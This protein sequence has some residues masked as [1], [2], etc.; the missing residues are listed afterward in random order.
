MHFVSPKVGSAVRCW[1]NTKTLY[2]SALTVQWHLANTVVYKGLGLQGI[3]V[4]V[5]ALLLLSSGCVVRQYQPLSKLHQP[6]VVEPG[7]ANFPD[8]AL[9]VHCVPEGLLKGAQA[10]ELCDK[11]AVL[12]ENQGATVN[13]VTTP[14][15][16]ESS[17]GEAPES[18]GATAE[19]LVLELRVRRTHRSGR[20][21]S[22]VPFVLSW[23]VVPSASEWSFAQDVVLRDETG[24]LL[25]T[26]TLEGRIV[27][28]F[29]LGH[30]LL[31]A[32][33][34]LG[35]KRGNKTIGRAD[36][37]LSRDLYGQLSQ[38]VLNAELHRDVLQAAGESR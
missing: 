18:P 10:R 5:V 8:L 1:L 19:D 35:H 14:G 7:R 26:E 13:T 37:D 20:P 27:N 6:I 31:T 30:Y 11:V 16:F 12:F 4:W 23:S 15:R 36:R 29:G 25:V 28:R 3:A 32:L 21:L 22:W 38:L 34:D 9:T 2:W 24:F 17:L 33:I